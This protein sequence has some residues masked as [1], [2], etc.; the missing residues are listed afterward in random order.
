MQKNRLFILLFVIF[1]FFLGM[2]LLSSKSGASSQP[3]PG[4]A[5]NGTLKITY[6]ANDTLFPADI[7]APTFSWKYDGPNI[8]AWNIVMTA[9]KTELLKET[10]TLSS[11]KPGKTL[12]QLLKEKYS[13]KEITFSVQG[14]EENNRTLKDS[15]H[16]K[17]S[18]DEV[19]ARIFYRDVPLP[20]IFAYKNL[21]TIRWRLGDISSEEPSKILMGNLSLCGN[22]HSF[23][24]DGG[25]LAMDV[26]YA[27]DK[28]SYVV[29][30]VE[31]VTSLTMDKIITW[32]SY[33]QEDGVYT[34]GL[35]SQ[36]SPDGRYII[37]TVK[38]HSVFVPKDNLSYSQL[39]FPIKGILVVYDTVTKEF[40]ALPGA[41]DPEFVQSNPEWSPDGSYIVFAK[42]PV[43]H[44]E[45]IDKSTS[46]LLDPAIVSDFIE[47]RRLF[48]YDLYKIPFNNGKGGKVEAIPG[49]SN[50]GMS[51]YFPKISP[52]GKWLVFCRAN[53]FMLLQPDSRLYI[54]PASGGTPRE[55]TCN[56]PQMNSWHSWSPNS[57]WLVFAS[58]AKG[59]YTQLYLTH[60]DDNGRDTPAVLLENLVI[61]NRA[62]N[63]PEFV[64]LQGRDW[65]KIVDQFS[66]G[67]VYDIRL[68][69]GKYSDGDIPGA[70]EKLDAAA[71]K[72]P[73]DPSIYYR[74]GILKMIRENIDD[75]ITDFTKSIELNPQYPLVYE[76]RGYAYFK[77]GQYD[78]ALTDL[79]KALEIYPT[80][81]KAYV[82]RGEVN[83]KLKK[84]TE[85]MEDFNK[86]ISI[87]STDS[88][89]Y[90]CRADAWADMGQWD[91]AIADYDQALDLE[92]KSYTA[93]ASR[94]MAKAKR[95]DIQAALADMENAISIKPDDAGLYVF[96]GIIKEGNGD[97]NGA[98]ADFSKTIQAQPNSFQAFYRRAGAEMKIKAV[99]EAFADIDRA[100][101]LKP[102]DPALYLTKGNF[103][104]IQEEMQKAIAEFD[105]VIK[106]DS[107]DPRAYSYK[108]DALYVLK[109][110]PAAD[111]AFSAAVE[112]K[113]DDPANYFKRGVI[114]LSLRKKEE[115][116]L[117]LQKAKSLGHGRAAEFLEKY[118]K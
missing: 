43:Y 62:I 48:K 23:T 34:F 109:D 103:Y 33:K 25:T 24:R 56:T 98:I 52:D 54:M 74:R 17:I 41:D 3:L 93:M 64:N 105:K 88:N 40:F 81:Q 49:A 57:K 77:L 68:A 111:T 51:N 22:C 46:V 66:S 60:I 28:G 71:G 6:P 118:C 44:S 1:T 35:L 39:F 70:I 112:L 78:K 94:A 13:E 7:I 27:N 36:I 89:S 95:G 32:S 72:N 18:A 16:I 31:K 80:L 45:E 75:A 2:L 42:S 15:I 117:D 30:E 53:S 87:N 19:A 58:K 26:D 113:P 59:A 82:S 11:W 12:W 65:E 9:G 20:F 92:P 108:G 29:S 61:E 101:Q 67:S 96:R 47:G 102:D 37:S 79:N 97:I 85:A 86:A 73:K 10:I 63:I 55:M 21:E 114:R 84:F 8:T 4:K 90:K 14:K 115:A 116:C 104:L 110:F 38:D 69:D 107:R 50:N 106:L 83:A 91:K 99:Q 5:R 76:N 100:I